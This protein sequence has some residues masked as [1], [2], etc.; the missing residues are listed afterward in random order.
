MLIT[1]P[2]D[3]PKWTPVFHVKVYIIQTLNFVL[4]RRRLFK[5]RHVIVSG[6]PVELMGFYLYNMCRK[7]VVQLVIERWAEAL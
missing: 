1:K 7:L 5:C 3:M 6:W 2:L 4:G